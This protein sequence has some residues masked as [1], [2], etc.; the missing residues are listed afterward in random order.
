VYYEFFNLKE[1]PFRLTCETK[2]FYLGPEHTHAN[3]MMEFALIK[4][5]G[6][7]LLTG[8]VGSGKSMLIQ[9]FLSRLDENNKVVRINQTQL[10]ELEFFQMIL[11]E[12]AGD[13]I[14]PSGSVSEVL[15]QISEQIEVLRGEGRHTIIVIDEAQNL[16]VKI[17]RSLYDLSQQRIDNEKISTMYMVG[18]NKLRETLDEPQVRDYFSTINTRYHLGALKLDDIRKYIYHRLA[19]AGGHKSVQF[20]DDVFP[21]IETYTGG[22][23][24]LIN[25]LVDHILTYSYL[26]D[27]RKISSK[28][29]DDAIADLQWLPFGV[30]YGEEQPPKNNQTFKEERRQSY[31]LVIRSE[32]KV[33]GEYFIRKKRITIGRHREN[34]LRIDDALISRQHAQIIQQGRTIYLRD[35]N[36]TNG[37]FVESKRVDIA[38]LEIGTEIKIGGCK[39]TFTRSSKNSPAS[40]GG[41]N[42]SLDLAATHH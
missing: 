6:L 21:I 28:V 36:S 8:E 9:H 14:R 22:R 23:P 31:K 2:F 19:I 30:Q 17:L 29:V 27:I 10:T 25:V 33:Q 38:P 39:L 35:L 3:A 16:D 34:D 12:L 26:E 32:D 41:T 37:T 1:H 15:K 11:L 7:M 5:Q 40:S 4:R 18:Q 42:H 13:E 20:N 24:R